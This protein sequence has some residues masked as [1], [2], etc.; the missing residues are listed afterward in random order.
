[1]FVTFTSFDFL[2]L[3]HIV[4]VHIG[5]EFH[6][7]HASMHDAMILFIVQ[8]RRSGTI[9]IYVDLTSLVP[10]PLKGLGTRLIY[11][12]TEE[13]TVMKIEG[14]IKTAYVLAALVAI[15]LQTGIKGLGQSVLMDSYGLCT[16]LF[17]SQCTFA[18]PR[19]CAYMHKPA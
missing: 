5:K 3:W 18:C 8:K 13:S 9:N 7:S 19:L 2:L 14:M 4:T 11:T 12:S 10:S 16:S 15:S 17:A 1:M 6:Y